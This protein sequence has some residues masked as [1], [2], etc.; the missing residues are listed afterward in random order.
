MGEIRR[1]HRKA[2]GCQRRD[3]ARLGRLRQVCDGCVPTD[4]DVARPA[5]QFAVACAVSS[6]D[7]PSRPAVSPVHYNR[8]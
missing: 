2:A 8:Y 7:P 6:E 3:E 5:A 1:R 4:G